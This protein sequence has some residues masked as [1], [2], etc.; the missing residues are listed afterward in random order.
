MDLLLCSVLALNSSSWLFWIIYVSKLHFY[1]G[2]STLVNMILL[3][4]I[5]WVISNTTVHF[6][7][8]SF[9]QSKSSTIALISIANLKQTK[10]IPLMFEFWFNP[11]DMTSWVVLLFNKLMSIISHVDCIREKWITKTKSMYS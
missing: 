1:C 8:T 9:S 7:F 2:K 11:S 3:H 5:Q 10:T 4:Y 6:K